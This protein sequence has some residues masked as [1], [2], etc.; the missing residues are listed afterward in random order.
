MAVALV[1]SVLLAS[2]A[3]AQCSPGGPPSPAAIKR[4]MVGI[5]MD[6]SHRVLEG[7]DVLIRDPRRNVKTDAQ[8]RFI[9]TDLMPGDNELTVRK[10][11]YEIA[12]QTITVTD[13]GG[14]AR[15]CLVPES[16]ALP[17]MITAA[18]RT[19]LG[20]VIGDS[21]YAVVSGAEVVVVG[22]GAHATTDSTGGFFIPLP[23][24][25]YAVQ[26]SKKGFGTQLLS[27]SIPADSGREVAVWL[28]SPPRNKNRMAANYFDMRHRLAMRTAFSSSLL[29]A[30]DLAKT[31]ADF[32][33]TVQQAA[34]LPID[35][36]C[37][38]I[39]D[40]GPWTL[41]FGLIDKSDLALVE[42]YKKA[43]S[44][45]RGVTSINGAGTG[46]Q[47]GPPTRC[48]VTVFVWFKP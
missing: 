18:K 17:A 31:S 22:A 43:P 34:R 29:S 2:G 45:P 23:K 46:A 24:G 4:A 48:R 8:G 36:D 42:V 9:F 21:T 7:V 27:V 1:G 25:V 47:S 3:R 12:V 32:P 30:E 11:G 35:A 13:S 38:A 15:F 44:G 20:G 28:S 41:P 6:S 37:E 5:V 40:G 19:G 26:V 39:I 14:V 33:Q 16:R 10:L